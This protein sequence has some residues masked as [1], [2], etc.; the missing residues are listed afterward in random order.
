MLR[1]HVQTLWASLIGPA[2]SLHE[3]V[4]EDRRLLLLRTVT[5]MSRK[6]TPSVR[7][8]QPHLQKKQAAPALVSEKPCETLI[9]ID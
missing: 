3:N 1:L 6:V 2:I 8:T 4:F 9:M 7:Q 5:A